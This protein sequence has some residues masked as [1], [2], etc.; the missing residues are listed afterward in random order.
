MNEMNRR[1]F[2]QK[3]G[4]TSAVFVIGFNVPLKSRMAMASGQKFSTH[5]VMLGANEGE[6]V[7][8]MDKAEMGQG[9]ITGQL[10]L[11][12]EEA[13]LNPDLVKVVTAPVADVYGTLN[14][15]Q[16]TGGSTSTKDR[17]EVLRQAGANMRGCFT[18]A[19]AKKWQES[20]NDLY[21]EDGF[22]IS[23]KTQKKESFHTLASDAAKEKVE[24]Y[25]LKDSKDF[26]YIAKSVNKRDAFDKSTGKADYG[27]DFNKEGLYTA[28]ILRSPTFG[29][30]LKSFDAS[31][32]L[33][34]PGIHKVVKTPFGLAVVGKKYWQ[35]NKA[36]ELVKVEWDQG[37]NKNL[38]SEKI[39][40][41]YAEL[42][43]SSGKEV[44]A[45][46]EAASELN[47]ANENEILEA[48]Y[49]LPYLAHA[50]ME[51][52]N[53]AAEITQDGIDVWSPN[54]AP[55]LLR[56]VVADYLGLSREQV[57][58][59]T[60]KYLGGGFGRRS[61]LD[62]TLEAVALANE[63]QAPV[64]VVWSREDDTRHS[65]M[66]P[67]SSHNFKAVV[68][69]G[70]IKA[71]QHRIAAESIM[72]GVMPDWI[73]LMLPGWV[74]GFIRDGVGGVAGAALRGFNFHMTTGEG[75]KIDYEV[76]NIQVELAQKGYDIPLHFWRSVGHSFNGFVV[77]SFMDEVAA[78]AKKD[79]IEFKK[80]LLKNNPR[81]LGVIN[82]VEK[83]S[84]WKNPLPEGVGRG[85]AYHYSFDSFV[86]EVAEVR[87][88]DGNIKVDKVYCAVDCG[89]AV[90]PDI[91]KDQMKSGIIYGLSAALHGAITLKDGAVV[92]SNFH[93]YP[94]IRMSEAPEIE[95]S[96]IDSKEAPTGVGEPGLPPLAAAV[97]NALFQLTGK[98]QRS[99]PFEA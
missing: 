52:M 96:I 25:P 47:T 28:V 93:D 81:A 13:G 56:N 51:P 49:H 72:Q 82:E 34:V 46:G 23:K 77:E 64:K 38:S 20:I 85:F 86:A 70:E 43:K 41:E 53:A 19:A 83:L 61:T 8:T 79:P 2:L 88:V 6:V 59:H 15:M 44:H 73:P 21:T 94:V 24:D 99:L 69:D 58:I 35:V 32:A 75:A 92:Q 12:C 16:I 31:E 10:T 48:N 78:K 54:Q 57:R 37:E 45:S 76:P 97:G 55:T 27:I 62:Y 4:L 30:Q 42:L 29:G 71:W 90:N 26:K 3:A 1:E 39:K 65:P 11:F 84:S 50:T 17:W 98:R 33:N 66:R 18:K 91:V 80:S 5:Y 87:I 68:K 7:F 89:V 9:V 67:V 40:S 22:V 74:P 95:V 14:G 60:T 63:L 36:R